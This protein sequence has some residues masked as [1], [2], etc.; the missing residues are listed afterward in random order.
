MSRRPLSEKDRLVLQKL[1]SQ[2][3]RYFARERGSRA[4]AL[5]AVG[6]HTNAIDTMFNR[7]RVDIGFLSM[8]LD[9]MDLEFEDLVW[10]AFDFDSRP[11]GNRRLRALPPLS[12]GEKLFVAVTESSDPETPDIDADHRE[13]LRKAF[14]RVR[15]LREERDDPSE[16]S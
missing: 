1:R 16:V 3:S 15:Q 11:R 9:A 13:V 2:L 4:R 5:R 10:D 12:A 6:V 8:V 7:G 14:E